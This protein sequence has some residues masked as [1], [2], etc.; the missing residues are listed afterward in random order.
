MANVGTMALSTARG[1]WGLLSSGAVQ[2]RSLRGLDDQRPPAWE[3]SILD[4]VAF[5]RPWNL[6]IKGLR[7]RARR[8]QRRPGVTIVIVNWNTQ[9]VTRDTLHAVQQLTSDD[10]KIMIVDNGSVDASRQWL[11]AEPSVRSI[12]LPANVGHA[13]ALDI[14]TLLATTDTVVT[15]DSDAV[16]LRFGWLDSVLDPLTEEGVVLAGL[17]SRR[18]FVHPVFA[19]VEVDAFV[20]KNLSFQVWQLPGLSDDDRIWGQNCWDTGELMTSRLERSEYAFVERT[21][22]PVTGLPGMTVGDVVY[23]HGGITRATEEADLDLTDDSYRG[24]RE[25]LEQLLPAEALSATT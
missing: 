4:D 1:S 24:W 13:V 22:N 11:R 20:E 8:T 14:A 10:V 25:A 19:G 17:Q 3:A 2:L 18:N 23:H 12:T 16:P 5:N 15:L 21:P 6:I 7:V 9:A